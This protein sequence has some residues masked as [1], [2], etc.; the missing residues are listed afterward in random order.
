MATARIHLARSDSRR[1]ASIIKVRAAS[2]AL[3]DPL[4]HDDLLILDILSEWRSPACS[5]RD[6]V[7]IFRDMLADYAPI[8]GS[9]RFWKLLSTVVLSMGR[10]LGQFHDLQGEAPDLAGLG[11]KKSP[12]NGLS[13]GRHRSPISKPA[14]K[15]T[16]GETNWLINNPQM[17]FDNGFSNLEP[18]G[19]HCDR[20]FGGAADG[21]G[22][23]GMEGT[24]IIET[25]VEPALTAVGHAETPPDW[26]TPEDLEDYRNHIIGLA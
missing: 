14:A 22:P 1:I 26:L 16:R 5:Y 2:G 18:R 12:E 3:S 25:T 13:L 9:A 6:F 20:G 19:S 11:V 15:F 23:G 21:N 4:S 10:D 7:D 8:S 17:I 24:G